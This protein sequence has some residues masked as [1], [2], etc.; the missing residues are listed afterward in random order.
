MKSIHKAAASLVSMLVSLGAATPAMAF[1]SGAAPD[2]DLGCMFFANPLASSAGYP[3]VNMRE[4]SAGTIGMVAWDDGP[5]SWNLGTGFND[6]IS[7]VY[8]PNGCHATLWWDNNKGGAS[9]VFSPGFYDLSGNTWEDDA[10]TVA[11]DCADPRVTPSFPFNGSS[12]YADAPDGTWFTTSGFTISA[13]IRLDAVTNWSRVI[14]FGN[15][16]A[17]DNVL[18]AASRGTTG[19]PRFDVYNGSSHTYVD[20]SVAIPI[21]TWTHLAAVLTVDNSGVASGY[22]Y[23]NGDLVGSNTSMTAPNNVTRTINYI[24][25]S[26]WSADAYLHGSLA[27]LRIF[28]SVLSSGNVRSLADGVDYAVQGWALSEEARYRYKVNAASTLYD[29]SRNRNDAAYH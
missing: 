21:G 25:R 6:A 9:T 17:A 10:S 3:D 1:D 13:W 27:D 23:M 5:S 11:C 14:D 19:K 18:L 26:N 28:N 12:Q 8:V 24:G 4:D 20:S 22:L 29:V 2:H 16:P 7:A 15:G